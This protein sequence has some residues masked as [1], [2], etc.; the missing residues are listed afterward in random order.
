MYIYLNM[1]HNIC[2][3][4]LG[5]AAFLRSIDEQKVYMA[6]V[7]KLTYIYNCFAFCLN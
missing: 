3:D 2:K 1:V 6:L 5:S 4:P 7:V